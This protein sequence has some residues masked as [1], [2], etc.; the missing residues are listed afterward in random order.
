MDLKKYKE[1]LSFFW[2]VLKKTSKEKFL[3]FK[4]FLKDIGINEVDILKEKVDD[5]NLKDVL[6]DID[7]SKKI[8]KSLKR[9]EP[10]KKVKVY[11]EEFFLMVKDK[12]YAFFSQYNPK[13]NELFIRRIDGR[14]IIEAVRKF[15]P[16]DER[17]LSDDKNTFIFELSCFY[18]RER[19]QLEMSFWCRFKVKK[20]CIPEMKFE[21]V[22][23][24]DEFIEAI[25]LS[26]FDKSV[27][28]AG[29]YSEGEMSYDNTCE[30]SWVK[31]MQV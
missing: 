23:L 1:L 31:I 24:F 18:R 16:S 15:F 3:L 26:D 27:Q 19:K 13:N 22:T 17:I 4:E 30:V 28:F 25:G 14:L 21:N 8:R 11:I 5:E 6:E 12:M 7:Y 29:S 10:P 2:T 20:E 9:Y